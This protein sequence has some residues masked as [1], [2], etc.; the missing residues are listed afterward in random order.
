M[1]ILQQIRTK[2]GLAADVLDSVALT[3]ALG[4]L[5]TRINKNRADAAA[6]E[7]SIPEAVV[8]SIDSAATE[9]RKLQSLTS[10]HAALVSAADATRREIAAAL[11]R[12]RDAE[13]QEVGGCTRLGR[14]TTDQRT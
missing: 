4:D 3:Q 7:A 10:E 8:R 9:R 5:N 13:L 1:G 6:I 12:E 2:L 14:H 11:A